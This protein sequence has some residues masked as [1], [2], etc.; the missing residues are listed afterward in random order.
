M[1]GSDRGWLRKCWLRFSRASCEQGLLRR[2]EGQEH[3]A[4]LADQANKAIVLTRLFPLEIR[5]SHNHRPDGDVLNGCVGFR[6]SQRLHV[7]D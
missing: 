2:E 1:P 3:L 4:F 5:L 7:E 6:Y